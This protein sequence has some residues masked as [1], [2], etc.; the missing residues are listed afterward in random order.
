MT[1]ET[2]K[3]K[4]LTHIPV[5]PCAVDDCSDLPY[6]VAKPLPKKSF[7]MYISGAPGSGKTNLWLSM[8]T[9][10]PTKKSVEKPRFY[11][12]Y[13]DKIYLIS[14]SLATLPL[15]K[16]NLDPDRVSGEFS[17][18]MLMSI[19]SEEKEDEN[20]NILIL[21]DDCIKQ[22]KNSQELGKLIL[23][24]RH[25]C[26]NP[27]EEGQSGTSVMITAQTYNLLPLNLRKNMSH[28]AIFRT[29]NKKE[30]Q[31]I[32][33]E[34]MSDLT[35]KQAREVLNTAWNSNSHGFLFVDCTKPTKDRYYANFDKIVINA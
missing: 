5:L 16:L 10:R 2:I 24:R 11:Y 14:N 3:N 6:N 20:S 7:A 28:V 13:F 27:D 25:C 17:D 1:I 18:G 30:L 19:I 33:T 4:K 12:R 32:M 23:N 34:L 8:L 31:S 9:S 29:E 15:D 35:E 21:L 26:Q 22:L